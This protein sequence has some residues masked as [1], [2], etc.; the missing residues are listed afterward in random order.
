MFR[1]TSA[2]SRTRLPTTRPCASAAVRRFGS[3]R[4]R[5]RH[6]GL[7]RG[8]R[9]S[10][11]LSG[12]HRHTASLLRIMGLA[13]DRRFVNH[14][15]VL[16]RAGWGAG[17][18]TCAAG[19]AARRFRAD[20]AGRAGRQTKGGRRTSTTRSGVDEATALA[21]GGHVPRGARPP[22]G[23]NSVVQRTR[24]RPYTPSSHPTQASRRVPTNAPTPP[25]G[26]SHLSGHRETRCHHSHP[27]ASLNTERQLPHS[28]DKLRIAA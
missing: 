2:R 13:R 15:R 14:R 24:E 4:K 9:P 11:W 18:I 6:G 19:A 22:R 12:A 23:G 7:A 26:A 28:C 20:P 25:P 21:V 5:S 3:R 10:F 1:S 8:R 17:R 27:A 16:N